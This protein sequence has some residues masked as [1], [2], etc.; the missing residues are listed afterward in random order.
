[1][2]LFNQ[3]PKKR[4][5]QK[6]KL[7]DGEVWYME[8]FI[9]LDKANKYF[10]TFVDGINWRQEE[11]KMYGKTY[12]V[13]RKTA[14][15]GY[16]GFNYK[17][18]GILCNPEPWTKELLGIKKVIESFVDNVD[19]NSVLLNLYRDG[20][21]KVGW[22]ADDEKGLGMNPLIASVSLG[23]TRRFD[24]KHKTDP[25]EK[26][27]LE[28]VPGSLVIMKGALQHNWLH[29]IPIQKKISDARINLTFRTIVN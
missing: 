1:M 3:T 7:K 4:E 17:Y 24:L 10:K 6:I 12:P 22:H 16:E 23:A 18:S 19:F 5:F 9:P 20:S 8:N 13:P 15:Y 27:K 28:L 14:W 11:I 21:D 2:D 25:E 26:L 29:Q